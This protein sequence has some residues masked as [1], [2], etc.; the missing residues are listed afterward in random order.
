M[1][2]RLTR[3]FTAALLV[4]GGAAAALTVPPSASAATGCEALTSPVSQTSSGSTDLM[5]RWQSE[6]A[7]AVNYGFRTSY[8]QPFNAA[9]AAGTD[10]EPIGRY[11][12]ATT[13][14]FAW[15]G[16]S[17]A[18]TLGAG[19]ARQKTEFHAY[20][21]QGGAT[22]RVAVT[23]H[24]KDGMHRY[25]SAGELRTQLANAGWSNAGT[26]FWVAPSTVVAAPTPP[27]PTDD[28]EFTIAV[29]PDSQNE[30]SS[31]ARQSFEDRAGWLV[32]NRASL[33]L[34]R[35]IHT[36]DVVS[37]D[38]PDHYQ[39]VKAKTG[40]DKLNTANIPWNASVGNH[41]TAA[42][43]PGGSA[44]F[45]NPSYPGSPPASVGLRDTRTFNTYL[46]RQSINGQFEAG[47]V[48]NSY[49]LF[50]AGGVQWMVLN[51]EAWPR[52]AVVNWAKGVVSANPKANVILSTH[53]FTDSAGNINGGTDGYG[54]N[55]PHYVWANL[56]AP[57]S[58][59]TVVL[60]GHIG[61]QAVSTP[62][63]NA[64]QSVL[65]LNGTWHKATAVTRL[66]TINTAKGTIANSWYETGAPAYPELS[67]TY[68]VAPV[69]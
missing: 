68:P 19:Y 30:V 58:N 46:N 36:G 28:P 17:K 59:I 5:T 21:E 65:L 27:P 7:G 16:D 53:M 9:T 64:G 1:P 43:C 38:T 57:N 60:S 41:D 33:D 32:A 62:V 51:L 14:D 20:A 31:Q 45:G 13:R 12:N 42:V 39:F 23:V 4:A 66:L 24:V 34:R 37:W 18:A 47:K 56:V 8:G 50:S 52:T 25:A 55:S 61:S 48:D 3:S 11:Y 35:V 44:C 49:G 67:A 2:L 22:C 10:L 29:I 63:N 26:A 40:F 69:R 15:I 6:S 54:A